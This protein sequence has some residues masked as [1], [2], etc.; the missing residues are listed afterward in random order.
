MIQKGKTIVTFLFILI[1]VQVRSENG[2]HSEDGERWG[3]GG[4]SL[5]NFSSNKSFIPHG[6]ITHYPG[7]LLADRVTPTIIPNNIGEFSF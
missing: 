2:S 1:Y 7:E 6:T 4:T 5:H 3:V